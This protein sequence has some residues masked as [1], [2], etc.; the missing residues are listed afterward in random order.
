[1]HGQSYTNNKTVEETTIESAHVIS[2]LM[3]TQLPMFWI[4]KL[5]GYITDVCV[6][7]WQLAMIVDNLSSHEI[8]RM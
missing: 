3:R 7:W 8:Y 1:M 2:I 4:T 6:N 5:A